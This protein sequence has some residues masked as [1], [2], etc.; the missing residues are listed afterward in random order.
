MDRNE[1]LHDP[2]HLGVPSRASKMISELMVR[3]VQTVHLSWINISTVSK[4]TKTSFHLSLVTWEYHLVRPKWFLR[5]WYIWRKPCTYLAQ[6]LTPLQTDRNELPFEPCHP[7][8][9]SSASKTI[10]KPMVRM[11]Q[12]MHL[13]CTETNTISKMTERRFY[14]THTT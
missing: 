11:A 2:H 9:P 8:V 13:S 10:S 3:S 12:N 5:L 4:W 1:I 7:R 6:K 14:L